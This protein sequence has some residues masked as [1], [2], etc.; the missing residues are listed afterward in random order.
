M[1]DE[2]VMAFA[3]GTLPEDE[4]AVI[5]AR[6]AEDPALAARVEAF[7]LSRRLVS[8]L[9]PE[10]VSPA[11]EARIRAL[12][13][14]P[15]TEPIEPAP[16]RNVLPFRR[17]AGWV[18]VVM[19]AAA[20]LVAG[21]FLGPLLRPADNG[22][23]DPVAGLLDRHPSGKVAM[24]AGA[25]VEVISSFRT[26]SD[27]LCREYEERREGATLLAISCRE[28]G[29]WVQHL[30]LRTGAQGGYAPA[31]GAEMVEHWLTGQSASPPLS[32]EEEAS[33]LAGG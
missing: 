14:P 11:L 6:L 21:V 20:A 13:A 16:A 27:T 26:G 19:A 32:P 22:L 10:P 29:V 2:H 3:D 1:D 4:A 7:R 30:A 18:P 28:A 12:A 23:A 9:P 17:R 8:Q 31:S 25:E 33:A 5:R 15:G 24:I